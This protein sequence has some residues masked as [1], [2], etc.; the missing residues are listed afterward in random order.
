[1]NFAKKYWFNWFFGLWMFQH[2]FDVGTM[3]HA[4]E[5]NVKNPAF[6]Q[7]KNSSNAKGFLWRTNI[8]MNIGKIYCGKT[9]RQSIMIIE[10]NILFRGGKINR[11]C[12]P[13]GDP[14]DCIFHFYLSVDDLNPSVVALF[15][16]LNVVP[17]HIKYIP[18]PCEKQPMQCI[19]FSFVWFD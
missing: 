17:T 4:F 2:M 9:I 6:A 10:E 1:M 7:Q 8:N 16:I 13:F 12:R 18:N 19:N 5:L 15:E 14:D 11:P 3:L